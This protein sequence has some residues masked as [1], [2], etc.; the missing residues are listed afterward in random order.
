MSAREKAESTTVLTRSVAGFPRRFFGSLLTALLLPALSQAADDFGPVR[1]RPV[2]DWTSPLLSND[3]ARTRRTDDPPLDAPP[4]PVGGSAN[5]YVLR[6]HA[7]LAR[8]GAPIVVVPWHTSYED[9]TAVFYDERLHPLATWRDALG[10]QVMNATDGDLD[11]DGLPEILLTLRMWKPG[12]A[13]LHY[14]AERRE[15]QTVWEYRRDTQGIFHRGS[16]IGQFTASPGREAVFGSS[17]GELLLLD[18]HGKLLAN[19][20]LDKQAVIQR[21][22][23]I[24]VDADGYDEMVI[25]TGRSPG[26]VW[27]VRWNPESAELQVLWNRDVTPEGRGGDN[28]YEAVVHLQ[29]HP[30]GGPAIAAATEREHDPQTGSILLLDLKG[31]IAWQDVF[32]PADRRAGGC[33]FRDVTG[34]HVPEIVGRSTGPHKLV[35]YSNRGRRIG[36]IQNCRTGSAGP[37]VIERLGRRSLLVATSQAYEIVPRDEQAKDK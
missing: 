2:S 19:R 8:N 30:D 13:V 7:A 16:A 3:S 15:L 12:V 18:R 17:R 36:G 23:L 1:L 37:C 9:C 11:E 31:N 34:D 25:A 22:D 10:E 24:D 33:D 35:I 20:V 6:Q 4:R 21:I 32:A 5:S 14:D 27:L 28:C 29:G 26:R